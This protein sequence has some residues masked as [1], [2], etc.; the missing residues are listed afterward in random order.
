MCPL[1]V[2]FNFYGDKCKIKDS[3]RTQRRDSSVSVSDQF[4]KAM[5]D[6]RKKLMPYIVQ[7][8]QQVKDVSLSY[9]VLNINRV[10][11]THNSPLRVQYRNCRN[12]T[13]G[14]DLL[15]PKG[16]AAQ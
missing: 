13:T 8:R 15:Q 6:R 7:A 1:V 14:T 2:K 9:D 16:E 11:Y 12:T 5:Q 4:S 3:A 10:R